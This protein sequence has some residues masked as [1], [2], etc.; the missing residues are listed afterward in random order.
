MIKVTFKD[1]A[2]GFVAKYLVE[3]AL[4]NVLEASKANTIGFLTT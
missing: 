2:G 4:A 3:K 1:H